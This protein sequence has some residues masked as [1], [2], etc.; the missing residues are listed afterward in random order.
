M[1]DILSLTISVVPNIDYLMHH[2]EIKE[3]ETKN[4]IYKNMCRLDKA[5]IFYYPHKFSSSRNARIP[6]TKIDINPKR[7]ECYNEMEALMLDIFSDSIVGPSDFNVSRI[8]VAAD[9]EELS[10][11]ILL[12]ILRIPRVRTESLSFFK[13]TIYVG[14]DPKIR[15]YD[16]TKELKS[17]LRKAQAAEFT[18]Y[19]QVLL[20]QGRYILALKWRCEALKRACKVSLMILVSLHHIST[21][22]S[23]LIFRTWENQ[24]FCK[25]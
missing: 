23:S 10:V 9:I 3:E 16:K 21:D 6:F 24:A 14:S 2:G 15:I 5:L 18:E 19:E 25:Y 22:W 4:H 20:S 12:S 13:G 11:D 17:K 1:I 8:D 7:F